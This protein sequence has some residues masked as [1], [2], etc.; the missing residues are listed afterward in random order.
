MTPLYVI[1]VACPSMQIALEVVCADRNNCTGVGVD[2][3]RSNHTNWFSLY[4][5]KR[6]CPE[7]VDGCLFVRQSSLLCSA[8]P[9]QLAF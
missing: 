2:R 3:P 1:N 5:L 6:V 8:E 4:T 7:I 9:V